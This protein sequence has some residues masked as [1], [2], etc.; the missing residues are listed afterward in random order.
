MSTF[1]PRDFMLIA[2][3]TD[4]NGRFHDRIKRAVQMASASRPEVTW[5]AEFDLSAKEH[6]EVFSAPDIAVAREVSNVVSAVDGLRVELAPLR[7]GW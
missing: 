6:V 4:G 3:S 1:A 2:R 7:N 5:R